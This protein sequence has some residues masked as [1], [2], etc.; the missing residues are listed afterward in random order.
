MIG[1]SPTPKLEFH[2]QVS[3]L[4]LKFS[5]SLNDSIQVYETKILITFEISI[6]VLLEF[7]V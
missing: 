6:V 7:E 1:L 3:F 2:F 5:L 4:T